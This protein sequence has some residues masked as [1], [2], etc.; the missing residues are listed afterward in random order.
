M[1]TKQVPSAL[2]LKAS[3][4]Y[5]VGANRKLL[6]QMG[7]SIEEAKPGEKTYSRWEYTG[8]L[9][10]LSCGQSD[11]LRS[12][13]QSLAD[14]R[15]SGD[16][17]DPFEGLTDILPIDPSTQ[18][19]EVDDF[20]PVKTKR[21]MRL[22]YECPW[23]ILAGRI[24][25]SAANTQRPELRVW[26]GDGVRLQD[27]IPGSLMP[28][29]FTGNR[30]SKIRFSDIRGDGIKLDFITTRT[31]WGHT[32]KKHSKDPESDFQ[33]WSLFFLKRL[34]AFLSGKS[35]PALTK[36]EKE[37]LYVDYKEVANVKVRSTRLIETLKTVDGMFQ[38]RFLACPEEEWNW[39]KFDQFVL[40]NLSHLLSDEFH[41]IELK[42]LEIDTKYAQLK[43][44]RKTFK[45]HSNKGTLDVYLNGVREKVISPPRW[46]RHLLT[47]WKN[48]KD[49]KGHKR[50][51]VHGL[52]SQTRGMGTPPSVV[53]LQAKQK[54]LFTLSKPSA[55]LPDESKGLLKAGLDTICAEMPDAAFTGL[56]TKA[57]ITITT[58]ACWSEL[59]K[60]GGT[61]TAV[62]KY[63][64]SAKFSL[65]PIRCL[66]T[67]KVVDR[68]ESSTLEPGELIFWVCLQKVLTMKIED[69]SKAY[70]LIVKEPGKGRAITKGHA[71]LKIVLDV[72][73]KIC[74]HPLTKLES[75]SS[76][77]GKSHHGWN[78]F[79]TFFEEEMQEVIFKRKTREKKAYTAYTEVY[80]TYDDV[81]VSSTDYENATDYLVH[82]VA[83]IIGRTWMNKC[84]IPP[85]LQ[86]IVVQTCYRPRLVFF[87]ATGP[88]KSIGVPTDEDTIR[89]ILMERGVLMG[90]PLTKVVL[91]LVNILVRTI[92]KNYSSE[93]FYA[94]HFDNPSEIADSVK[95]WMLRHAEH[96]LLFSRKL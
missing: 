20:R 60:D 34:K 59:S 40:W 89:C 10:V 51:F 44:M 56:T 73:N 55:P 52:F 22:E 75:S 4:S 71:C 15:E 42:T 79:K 17:G 38:Q 25:A 8:T 14:S 45:R 76:G 37:K 67:G 96:Q 12:I 82:E 1:S 28:I 74:S 43:A 47:M 63:M 66:E 77:M 83:E 31:F 70:A 19:I 61:C 36:A 72:V 9:S 7:F 33:T 68:V 86:K 93:R 29:S 16:A 32:L 27:P 5:S 48:A 84:G 6:A 62:S 3:G 18:P 91:H 50:L 78:F 88:L 35:D 13:V 87:K 85:L 49:L 46:I 39:E 21:H 94:G 41:D 23:K 11:T 2:A 80:E 26:Q 24:F 53:A 64:S 54:L 92:A 65:V 57:R 90:D 30:K 95:K 69:V 81:F 58:S